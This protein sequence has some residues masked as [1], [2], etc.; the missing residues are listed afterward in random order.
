MPAP[1]HPLHLAVALDRPG[2]R[3]PDPLVRYIRDIRLA[4]RGR[5]DFV[6]LDD[7]GQGHDAPAI[8]ARVVAATERIGLVAAVTATTP[9]AA[10]DRIGRGRVG[11]VVRV[12]GAEAVAR[13]REGRTRGRPVIAV[14]AAEAS[15]REA[16]ACAAELVFLRTAPTA[17][18]HRV[19]AAADG[20]RGGDG[21]RRTVVLASLPVALDASADAVALA[22]LIAAWYTDG[23]VDGFHL[24]PRD[25]DRD[26]PLLVDATVPVLQHR[27]LLRNF[28]P[29]NTLRE[30]LCLSRTSPEPVTG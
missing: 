6:T 16:A 11:W 20:L 8:P 23:T 30:H 25:P 17:A 2:A 22:E 28:Y 15:V 5:L 1:I 18:P 21:V 27:G 10:L 19:R 24:R 29:G 12:P 4:E 14:D 9:T 26:L 13:L 3:H 7:L